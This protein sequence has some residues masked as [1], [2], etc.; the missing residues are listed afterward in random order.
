MTTAKPAKLIRFVPGGEIGGLMTSWDEATQILRI[1][2]DLFQ[3]LPEKQK[4]DLWR[5]KENTELHFKAPPGV[6]N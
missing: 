4:L 5:L 6:C 2:V 1:N 3:F